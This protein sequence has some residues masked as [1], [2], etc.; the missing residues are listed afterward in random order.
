M[1]G[2][3]AVTREQLTH[4]ERLWKAGKPARQI[5]R[6]VGISH[7]AVIG[8]AHRRGWGARPSPLGAK[9]LPAAVAPALAALDAVG[10]VPQERS[11][12]LRG[13]YYSVGA[14]VRASVEQVGEGIAVP[15]IR[16]T[17]E[18]GE[19]RLHDQQDRGD[20]E[21]ITGQIAEEKFRIAETDFRT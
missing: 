7:N 10:R 15:S 19:H 17:C 20:S 16:R 18:L 4:A 14:E 9:Q 6:I 12:G 3:T 8:H 2:W 21:C 1:S 11:G 5:G 13:G